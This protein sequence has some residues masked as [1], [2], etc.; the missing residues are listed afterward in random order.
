MRTPNIL[1]PLPKTRTPKVLRIP[2]ELL[3]AADVAGALGVGTSRV[4]QMIRRGEL[5]HVRVGV[6][7]VRVPARAFAEHLDRLNAAARA[8]VSAPCPGPVT[9]AEIA[10][11]IAERFGPGPAL[12]SVLGVTPAPDL[13][14]VL[15][16]ASVLLNGTALVC[17][18][19]T[20]A[21]AMK[22]LLTYLKNAAPR[23]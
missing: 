14:A 6:R 21:D 23:R 3:S 19:G 20:E 4:H 9:L 5:P 2:R 11:R 17:D 16:Q 8:S 7:G 22:G 1:D 13:A 18:G 12:A 15:E 10:E